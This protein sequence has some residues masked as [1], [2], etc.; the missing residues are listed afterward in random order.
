MKVGGGPFPGAVASHEFGH[1]LGNP[2]EYTSGTCPDRSPVNTGT[3][4]DDNSNNI[5][6][7]LLQRLS[8]DLNSNIVAV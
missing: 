3:V 7:R 6:L 1:M 2:D 8:D 5:P 4:M